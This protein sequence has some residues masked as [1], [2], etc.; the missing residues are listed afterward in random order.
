MYLKH[1]IFGSIFNIF[2][3]FPIQDN[4]ISFVIDSNESFSGN[5]EYIKNEFEKKGQYKFNFYYKDKI[6]FSSLKKLATSKYVFLND[7]FFPIAFMKFKDETSV[8]QLWHAPGAFK[9]FGGSVENKDMLKLISDNTDF[10]IVTSKNIENYY[11]EA[12]QI[13]KSKI[14]PLGLPRADYYFKN[15]DVDGLREKFNK[16]F[17]ISPDKKIILYTPTFREDKLYNNVFNYLDLKKFNEQLADDYV[18]ALRL[19]PKIKNFYSE[20]ISVD[21][22]YIDC[23]NYKNEQELLLLA[24]ILI[25]DYSS[26]MI[27]FAMLSKPIIFFAYDLEN[28]LNN[29]RG[30][31]LNYKKDLPGPIVYNDDELITVIREGIDISNLNSFLK[32]QFDFIDGHASERVVDFVINEGGK[33]E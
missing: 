1:K 31:Y 5:L 7:N 16:K 6:S 30:F 28:Y 15:H 19:H 10:L 23:S 32:T 14:K 4:M 29:E 33:N 11:S 26:I 12:F 13:D 27:E 2:A 24:D 9:K 18:L 3:K 20:D 25:T 22:D 17:N 21:G 8:I